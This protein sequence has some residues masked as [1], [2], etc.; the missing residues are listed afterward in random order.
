MCAE[1]IIGA[2]KLRNLIWDELIQYGDQAFQPRIE[3]AFE[4]MIDYPN[5]AFIQSSLV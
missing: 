3:S 2:W 5:S 4:N 1:I